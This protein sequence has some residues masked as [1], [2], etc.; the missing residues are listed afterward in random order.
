M[1][2][3]LFLKSL[4]FL[5]INYCNEL[6]YEVPE[7]ICKRNISSISIEN[8]VQM[9]NVSLPQISFIVKNTF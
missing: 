7:I 5:F 3:L 6:E 8:K 9:E 1:K 2:C 4:L